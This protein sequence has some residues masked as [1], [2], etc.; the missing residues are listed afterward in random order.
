[1]GIAAVVFGALGGVCAVLGGL[2]A[3]GVISLLAPELTWMLWFILGGVL[4]LVSIAFNTG[5]KGEY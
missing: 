3:G 5:R 2:T 1:M 4:L